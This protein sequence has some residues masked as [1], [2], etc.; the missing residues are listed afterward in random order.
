MILRRV[1]QNVETMLVCLPENEFLNKLL[2]DCN[3]LLRKGGCY[4]R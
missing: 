2:E 3:K 1:K 4:V